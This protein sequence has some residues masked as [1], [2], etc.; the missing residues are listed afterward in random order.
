MNVIILSH[1]RS[2]NKSEGL[3]TANLNNHITLVWKQEESQAKTTTKTQNQCANKAELA[4]V[5]RVRGKKRVERRGYR[6][7]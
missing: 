2:L 1:K 4:Q 6:N 5:T 3:I 7:N